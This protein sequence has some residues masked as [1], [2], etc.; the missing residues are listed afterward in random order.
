MRMAD[1]CW[2]I[3]ANYIKNTFAYKSILANIYRDAREG[4]V[5]TKVM[6]DEALE[7]RRS[8]VIVLLKEEGFECRE[9]GKSTRGTSYLSISWYNYLSEQI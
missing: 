9:C 7:D 2:E 6:L 4:Y 8:M 3:S 5:S 1:E